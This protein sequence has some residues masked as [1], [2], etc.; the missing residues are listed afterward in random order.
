M[1]EDDQTDDPAPPRILQ[2]VRALKP[3]P[4]ASTR[5]APTIAVEIEILQEAFAAHLFLAQR[6]VNLTGKMLNVIGQLRRHG[7][8]GSDVTAQV[9]K[10]QRSKK[11]A[12]K[13]VAT[14]EQLLADLQLFKGDA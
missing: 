3:P 6:F 4:T 12:Q 10:F 14:L 1:T 9:E 11:N 13:E 2:F 7:M 5:K 8:A